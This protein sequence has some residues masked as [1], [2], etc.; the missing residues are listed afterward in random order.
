MK[1]HRESMMHLGRR[2]GFL[3]LIITALLILAACGS[4]KRNSLPLVNN[5]TLNTPTSTLTSSPIPNL[6]P[7][8]LLSQRAQHHP[9]AHLNPQLHPTPIRQNLLLSP[10]LLSKILL[11]FKPL[12]RI[13]RAGLKS[14]RPESTTRCCLG[15]IMSIT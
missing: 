14:R 13:S 8:Q 1:N 9:P 7:L 5:P 3:L 6:S 15:R 12:T 11:L 4:A 10:G 2:L